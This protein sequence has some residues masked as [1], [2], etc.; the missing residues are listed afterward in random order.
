M[1]H[2]LSNLPKKTTIQE[3]TKKKKKREETDNLMRIKYFAGCLSQINIKSFAVCKGFA[4]KSA[5]GALCLSRIIAGS[6]SPKQAA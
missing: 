4:E 6:W 2:N 1:F 3:K 5:N